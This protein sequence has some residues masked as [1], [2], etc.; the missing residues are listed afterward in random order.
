MTEDEK[1]RRRLDSLARFT[2]D[3]I[4]LPGGYKIGWDGIIGLI[5][6][7]GDIFGL[8][9]SSYLIHSS[10]KLGASKSLILR[11]SA[12]AVLETLIG[13][14]PIIGDLF[15]FAFKAN[16]RNFKLLERHISAPTET[17]RASKL[18]LAIAG[19]AIILVL[20]TLLFFVVRV[21]GWAWQL[22]F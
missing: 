15:D 4:S 6:W 3:S 18:W 12:N 22:V 19:T 2:D 17:K 16:R 13:F 9:M 7:V 14:I 20:L 1:L 10:A 21:I 11:M 5:P 8:A